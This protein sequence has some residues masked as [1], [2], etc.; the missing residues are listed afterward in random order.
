MRLSAAFL[1][2]LFLLIILSNVP[3]TVNRRSGKIQ[4]G[5]R[6][7]IVDKFKFT[8]TGEV[9]VAISSVSVAYS[10]SRPDF[11][12]IGF[13][14][15]SDD[16]IDNMNHENISC[17][18]D[19]KF[20]SLLFTFQELSPPPLCSFN[21]SFAVTDP[22]LYTLRFAN[23]NPLS[24]VT[25]DVR[26]EFYNTNNGTTK[27]DFSAG[28]TKFQTLYFSFSLIYLCLLG[29]WIFV[30][31]KKHQFFHLIH[32]LIG[33]LLVVKGLNLH[34]AKITGTPH[35]SD[36]LF[37]IFQ[38]IRAVLYY[39]VIAVMFKWRY[40]Q[41]LIIHIPIQVLAS[42][43]SIMVLQVLLGDSFSWVLGLLIA[44][45]ICHL[46]L[47]VLIGIA[48]CKK[49]SETDQAVKIKDSLARCT[50]TWLIY[51]VF[52][53]FLHNIFLRFWNS[54]YNFVWTMAAEIAGLDFY[55]QMF[56]MFRSS[57]KIEYF[58]QLKRQIPVATAREKV[59]KE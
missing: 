7:L 49:T 47:S 37:Y 58:V 9:S 55:M 41:L 10:L 23:C 28:Q 6:C 38:F 36:N 46:G 32:L 5:D 25:M 11:S 50:L 1:S 42:V 30:C 3:S 22:S 53:I 16:A 35:G 45:I 33:A 19:S 17:D 18:L 34:Y 2:F 26:T 12:Y 21:K 24:H 43:A 48:S 13:Y 56:S 27:D 57:E 54:D 59:H 44:D 8:H 39:T 20:I 51:I 31:I 15:V 4:S 40:F 52:I 14:L 29:F